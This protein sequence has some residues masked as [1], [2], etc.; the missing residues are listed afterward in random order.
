[1]YFVIGASGSGKT[2]VLNQ[3]NLPG[4]MLL[5][6][7]DIGVPQNADMQWRQS[8]TEQWLV[9]ML[10]HYDQAKTCLFGQMVLG[11]ILACPSAQQL[12]NIYICFLDCDDTTRVARLQKR[13]NMPITQDTLNWASWLRMHHHNPQWEQHVIKDNAD[14]LLDFSL[15]DNVKTWNQFAQIYY[16]DTT[17]LS[18]DAVTSEIKEWIESNQG[19]DDL[20]F[21]RAAAQDLKS[22]IKLII[23][24]PLAHKRESNLN[25][26]SKY[27]NAY[28]H[29]LNDPKAYLLVGRI[30]DQ[31]V[32]VAQINFIPNLTYQGGTRAQ[33][34]GVR[35][36]EQFRNQGIGKKLMQKAITLAKQQQCSLVQLTTDKQRPE[37][38]RF[39]KD[40]GFVDS[41]HGLKLCLTQV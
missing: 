23:N 16:C 12:D 9:K 22:I 31:V 1:M 25:E 13:A 40:L 19:T 5:D 20:R 18:L 15:W 2:A 28:Q 4:Y 21:S 8:A 17:Y 27:Q 26:Y 34:E 32:A 24:D 6:F 14:A 39:Y 41:H 30:K 3:L 10:K 11:E 29:I 37:A 38:L 7:D 35:V 33:V 36:D